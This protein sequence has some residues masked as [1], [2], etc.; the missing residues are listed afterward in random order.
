MKPYYLETIGNFEYWRSGDEVYRI[1][2]HSKMD[3]IDSYTGL[4]GGGCRWECSYQHFVDNRE[5]YI[6]DA[7]KWESDKQRVADIASSYYA[8]QENKNEK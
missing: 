8:E 7:T 2:T 5:L 1:N 6:Q 4:P 3:W